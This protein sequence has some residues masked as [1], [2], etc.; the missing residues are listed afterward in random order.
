MSVYSQQYLGVEPQCPQCG[1][2]GI[3]V[4]F[5]TRHKPWHKWT[6][7]YFEVRHQIVLHDSMKYRKHK[8]LPY[9]TRKMRG[10]KTHLKKICYIGKT[11]PNSHL[12]VTK[13]PV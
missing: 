12:P 6:G 3:I 1:E 2:K 9:K 4:A 10:R 7:V 13:I 11:Y 8:D 5:W